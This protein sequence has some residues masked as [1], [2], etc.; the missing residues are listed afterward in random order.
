MLVLINVCTMFAGVSTEEYIFT[1]ISFILYT[2]QIKTRVE[3]FT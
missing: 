2:V 1:Y 3:R